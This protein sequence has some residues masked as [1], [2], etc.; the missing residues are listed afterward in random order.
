[1]VEGTFAAS[2]CKVPETKAIRNYGEYAGAIEDALLDRAQTSSGTTKHIH[3]LDGRQ[4][5]G[6]VV[7]DMLGEGELAV[8]VE[9]QVPPVQLG[10]E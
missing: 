10:F 5:L 2:S 9:T 6:G 8:E 4:S 7:S 3:R 1:M